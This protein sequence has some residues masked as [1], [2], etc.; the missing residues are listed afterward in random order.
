MSHHDLAR[1]LARYRRRL[2]SGEKLDPAEFLRALIA[3]IESER[4]A[5][6]S[7]PPQRRAGASR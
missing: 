1:L 3:E 6:E 5:H 2:D 7:P 4:S